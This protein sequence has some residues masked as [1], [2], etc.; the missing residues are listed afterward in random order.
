[1]GARRRQRHSERRR[2]CFRTTLQQRRSSAGATRRSITAAGATRRARGRASPHVSGT[3]ITSSRS[4]RGTRTT[5]V[6]H[7]RG[8]CPVAASRRTPR[9]AWGTGT[10]AST[11][12]LPST[13]STTSAAFRSGARNRTTDGSTSEDAMVFNTGRSAGDTG[14]IR[15]DGS[16]STNLDSVGEDNGWNG[17]EI[18]FSCSKHHQRRQQSTVSFGLVDSATSG[19]SSQGTVKFGLEDPEERATGPKEEVGVGRFSVS[20]GR[21]AT[22]P[23]SARTCGGTR[24]GTSADTTGVLLGPS[25]AA[26]GIAATPSTTRETRDTPGVFHVAVGSSASGAAATPRSNGHHG[27]RNVNSGHAGAADSATNT[28]H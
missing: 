12:R 18:N 22:T 17:Y 21:S 2:C 16:S 3:G 28:K 5:R 27:T 13:R 15:S 1:M 14:G 10:L 11:V 4:V 26:S 24:R 7:R 23:T 9:R 6:H 19:V 8:P 20:T 25:A